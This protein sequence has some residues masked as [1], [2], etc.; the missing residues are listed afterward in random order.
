MRRSF[1]LALFAVIG[2]IIGAGVFA[3]PHLFAQIGLGWGSLVFWGIAFIVALTHQQFVEVISY[4]QGQ[5]RL[6]GYARLHL[7]RRWAS[8]ATFTHTIQT[9]GSHIAYLLLGGAFLQAITL[10]IGIQAPLR[11]SI[12]VVFF[13]MASVV[14]GGLARVAKLEAWATAIMIVLFLGVAVAAVVMPAAPTRFVPQLSWTAFGLILFSLS[15]LPVMGEVVE[16]CKRDLRLSRRVA[17]GGTLLAALIMWLFAAAMA[18]HGG[19]S[20]T[21]NVQSLVHVLPSWGVIVIP[22]LG[23]LAIST[24]FITTGEDLEASWCHDYGFGSRAAFLATLLPPLLV[25]LFLDGGFIALAAILGTVCC[26]ANGVLVGMMR[27]ARAEQE[28]ARFAIGLAL[29]TLFFFAFGMSSQI[30]SWLFL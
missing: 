7:G 14:R 25:A 5:H 26:G 28:K 10:A 29:L 21:N 4:T 13:L 30:V 15:G 2:T 12:F 19:A 22:L 27:L 20:L 1:L 24:S 18:V 3:L 9:Y 6:P 17:F 23:L 16:L 8:I 11:L